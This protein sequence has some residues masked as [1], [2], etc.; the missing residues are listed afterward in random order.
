MEMENTKEKLKAFE[1][2][3]FKLKDWYNEIDGF[4][5]E[6]NDFSKLKVLKLVFFS[7]AVNADKPTFS[8]LDNFDN[9]Y[10]M[11]YGH[12][13]SDIYKNFNSL[14]LIKVNSAMTTIN[15]DANYFEDL[16]FIIKSK[17]ENSIFALKTE[18][19]NLI[20][21]SAMELVE[22]SHMHFSWSCSFDIAKQKG[23]LSQSIPKEMIT[24]EKKFFY[25]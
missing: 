10:A 22:L 15:E 18:N 21:Y 12:V 4:N 25:L 8:L 24:F 6:S 5:F 13:E 7:A 3:I 1:Y 20:T 11:P 9:F 14:S 19:N 2:L 23:K 16:D 17:I